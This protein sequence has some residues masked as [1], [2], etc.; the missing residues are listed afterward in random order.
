MIS[1]EDLFEEIVELNKKL[2]RSQ[3]LHESATYL[4]SKRAEEL[5]ELKEKLEKTQKSLSE[6]A[7][8]KL[9]EESKKLGL[10][11]KTK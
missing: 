2:K 11:E 5:I 6:Y 8:D 3:E 4:S 10:Y 1:K 9:V 7:I